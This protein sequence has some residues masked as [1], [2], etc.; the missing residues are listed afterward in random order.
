MSP[1]LCLR[2]IRAWLWG[3]GGCKLSLLRPDTLP[4]VMWYL[5]HLLPSERPERKAG[6]GIGPGTNSPAWA[7]GGG[8]REGRARRGGWYG[9]SPLPPGGPQ[10]SRVPVHC[11]VF[12]GSEKQEL[13]GLPSNCSQVAGDPD[14]RKACFC[15]RL[16]L[17]LY[18]KLS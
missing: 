13:T 8:I 7:A 4:T 6:A 2:S 3:S 18:L 9:A 10:A 12:G 14:F 5:G 16:S 1:I 11:V 17:F 15:P